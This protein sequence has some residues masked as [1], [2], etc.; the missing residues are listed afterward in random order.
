VFAL[1]VAVTCD[2]STIVGAGWSKDESGYKYP[3]AKTTFD[4]IEEAVPEV[5]V[6]P[7]VQV[8]IE[9]EPRSEVVEEVVNDYL[10][11]VSNDYLPPNEAAAEIK[12]RQAQ[13]KRQVPV[14]RIYRRVYKKL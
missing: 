9:E 10:P 8:A 5:E 3:Q 11:P 14:K 2:V 6:I 7:E 1:I 13:A 4:V 12:K